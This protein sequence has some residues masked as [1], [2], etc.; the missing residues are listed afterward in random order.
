MTEDF[1]A[2]CALAAAARRVNQGVRVTGVSID[3]IAEATAK[4]H[5]IADLLSATEID[6]PH[7]QMF[8]GPIEDKP[9]EDHDLTRPDRFFYYSP[10]VGPLSPV[11]PPAQLEVDED[12][13]LVGTVVVPTTLAGPPWNYVHG[14]VIAEIFDELLGTAGAIGAPGG[15]TA[16]LT[17]RYHKPTPINE[18]IHLRGWVDSSDGRKII[19]KGEMHHGEVLTAS[20]EGLFINVGVSM[21]DHHA[22][23]APADAPADAI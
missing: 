17:V 13:A 2:R 18:E 15:V 10:I 14:G 19:A 22:D 12:R 3:D 5:E 1:E 21:V 23:D 20:A 6:A 9:M 8:L 16:Q 11:S 4:L 7:S